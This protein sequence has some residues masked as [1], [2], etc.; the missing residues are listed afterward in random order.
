MIDA[1]L[2]GEED[3]E[4]IAAITK[5]AKMT[6]DK[7][8][9]ETRRNVVESG[10]SDGRQTDEI[11]LIWIE[12]A[13]APRVH[14]STIF[15]RGETQA[16]VT[17]TLGTEVDALHVDFADEK[18]DRRWMLQ[19]NF[20]PYS[21]GEV[22]RMGG[23]KRREVG[24]GKLAHRALQPVFPSADDYKYV[25]RCSSDVLESNGSSSMATVCGA[26][27]SML[28][29][30]VPLKAPVAGIAMGL[31]KLDDKYV[32]LSDILGDEDHLGDMDFKVTGTPNGITAFQMDTKLGSPPEV[33]A[34]DDSSQRWPYAH[35]G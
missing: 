4:T 20:P 15:T 18:E 12:V 11:R 29:A 17:A 23:P 14:G 35:F 2:A 26:T 10:N 6:Q 33:W 16:F 24:H 9:S 34:G 22:R 8:V 25:V 13:M 31:I 27:L 5:D 21:T 3:E 30:G 32:V 19:Y 7:M 28:D 1:V